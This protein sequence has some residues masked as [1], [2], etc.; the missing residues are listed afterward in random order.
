VSR[1]RTGSVNAWRTPRLPPSRGLF[2]ESD[3]LPLPPTVT[4]K[5]CGLIIS[6]QGRAT[7][8]LPEATRRKKVSAEACRTKRQNLH[9]PNRCDESLF[10]L[11][12]FFSE[13]ERPRGRISKLVGNDNGG[14]FSP[15]PSI[16][17]ACVMRKPTSSKTPFCEKA[18]H[19]CD[20]GKRHSL[21]SGQAKP[22]KSS[23]SGL[24]C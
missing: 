19:I 24:A 9:V 20:R 8:A 10:S 7:P 23:P 15:F 21:P 22:G 1:F 17:F 12:R 18:I 6:E 5:S 11:W 3:H 2:S 13:Q 14:V 16:A 4:F